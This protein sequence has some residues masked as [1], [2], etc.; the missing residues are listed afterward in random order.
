MMEEYL[1]GEVTQSTLYENILNQL[2]PIK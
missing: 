2:A 1:S